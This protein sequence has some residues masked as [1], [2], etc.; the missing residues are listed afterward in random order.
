[1]QQQTAEWGAR[2]EDH[3]LDWFANNQQECRIE[4]YSAVM[5][6]LAGDD[7]EDEYIGKR[8]V[9]PS[10]HSIVLPF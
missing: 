9:L 6:A 10:S 4:N 3:R 5:D 1:M 8:I 7:I 2:I